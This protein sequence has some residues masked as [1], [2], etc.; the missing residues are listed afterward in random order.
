MHV[1]ILITNYQ[2]WALSSRAVAEVRRWSEDSIARIVV[3][4]D[5]SDA[6]SD[7]G[8]DNDILIHR[9]QQNLGYV[10]S[11]NVGMKLLTEDVVVLLDCDAYP[12]MNLVPTIL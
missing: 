2:A 8:A 1:G 10:A 9:N 5:A 7:M 3:V 4:D 12:L 11:V 6:P